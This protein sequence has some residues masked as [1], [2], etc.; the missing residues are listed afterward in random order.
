MHKNAS[1]ECRSRHPSPDS[2][3]HDHRPLTTCRTSGLSAH[4]L[5]N[6]YRCITLHIS[7]D[8]P[9]QICA[10]A[11]ASAGPGGPARPSG[12]KPDSWPEPEPDYSESWRKSLGPSTGSLKVQTFCNISIP[13]LALSCAIFL[14]LLLSVLT[15][16]A[17]RWEDRVKTER[18]GPIRGKDG[19]QLTNQRPGL[20]RTD[21][22]VV[23]KAEQQTVAALA[24]S[25]HLGESE[26]HGLK[27]FI[28][29][30][31]ITKLR[32]CCSAESMVHNVT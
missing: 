18:A 8:N 14:N 6:S 16:E 9:F 21:C 15:L 28:K 10:R 22:S 12:L 17:E 13:Q 24:V 7:S 31:K 19:G 11:G 27:H 1:A 3:C 32:R 20:R 5:K 25:C 30:K 26:K 23:V 4:I 2:R 29:Q